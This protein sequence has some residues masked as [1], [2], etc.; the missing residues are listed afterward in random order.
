MSLDILIQSLAG[1]DAITDPKSAEIAASGLEKV[2]Q[3][4][5]DHAQKINRDKA[6]S[7]ARAQHH[8]RMRHVD[9][10]IWHCLD[11]GLSLS[12]T[13]DALVIYDL[14]PQ[15]VRTIWPHARRKW[16]ENKIRKRRQKIARA[17]NYGKSDRQIAR[18]LGVSVRTVQR[19]LAAMRA[20][21]ER[22]RKSALK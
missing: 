11:D 19:D 13:I 3:Q 4:L 6:K 18:D 5:R 21:K 8:I 15:Q 1:P 22:A 17:V 12:Q 20:E 10:L 16:T 7:V 14:S 2:A 9:V